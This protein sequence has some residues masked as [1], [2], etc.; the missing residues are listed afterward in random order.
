MGV[1]SPGQPAYPGGET[2]ESMPV[3][4]TSTSIFVFSPKRMIAIQGLLKF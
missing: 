3:G 4:I 1:V 2:R